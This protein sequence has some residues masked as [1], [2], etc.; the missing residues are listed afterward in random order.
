[1]I[2]IFEKKNKYIFSYLI[3][4]L[5][6]SSCQIQAENRIRE[7]IDDTVTA[8]ADA[9]LTEQSKASNTPHATMT[10]KIT[11][12]H[13]PTVKPKDSLIFEYGACFG[14][15]IFEG[16]PIDFGCTPFD[17]K[18]MKLE[19][20]EKVEI[21]VSGDNDFLTPYCALYTTNG[22]LID[23]DYDDDNTGSVQC[24]NKNK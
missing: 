19:Y 1:M 20:L 12:T 7:A 23:S 5:L 22:K 17:K 4:C 24:I 8:H 6:F 21:R 11:L 16:D 15:E 18:S 9:T 14:S 10:P 13:R 2:R 3:L